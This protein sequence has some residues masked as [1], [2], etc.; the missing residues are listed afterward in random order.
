MSHTP[1]PWALSDSPYGAI[2]SNATPEIRKN[3]CL[4]TRDTGRI[5]GYEV[6]VA[7]ARR[8]VACVNACKG[9]S[10]DT[11]EKTGLVSAVGNELIDLEKERDTYRELC[12]ELLNKLSESLPF[13]EDSL[14]SNLFKPNFVKA[15]TKSI[16]ELITKAEAILG[17]KQ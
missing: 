5:Y 6:A 9:L 14:E 10:T 16:R 13:V 3:W 2:F 15:K 17:E 12:A 11:L 1:E 4:S 7:N 8:I